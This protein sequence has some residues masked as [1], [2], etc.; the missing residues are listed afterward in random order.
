MSLLLLV[1]SLTVALAL[2][3]A[4]LGPDG[5]VHLGPLPPEEQDRRGAVVV[6]PTD[7]ALALALAG[8]AGTFGWEKGRWSLDGAPIDGADPLVQGERPGGVAGTG[9]GIPDTG[10]W[11]WSEGRLVSLIDPKGG[12]T[13]LDW[14]EEGRIRRIDWADGTYIDIRR[15]SFGRVARTAG[16]G[17][18]LQDWS[19]RDGRLVVT[20]ALGRPL[21]V[22]PGP[23]HNGEGRSVEV[24]D[25]LGRKARAWYAPDEGGAEHLVGWE[26]PRGL[27]TW[28]SRAGQGMSVVDG[29]GRSWRVDLD[30]AGQV[31]R[32]SDPGGQRWS[33]RRD[34][35]G[36]VV[37]I[38]EPAGR[39]H[40]WERDGEGRL[41]AVGRG[42]M[43]TCLR[44]DPEGRLIE[45]Q[46]PTGGLTRLDR[47]GAGH[48]LRI[49]D[50]LGNTVSFQRGM[51]G[52]PEVID[53]RVPGER[54]RIERDLLGRPTRVQGPDGRRLELVRSG[55]GRLIS[56][57][58]PDRG[59]FSLD[60]SAAGDL[61]RLRGPGGQALGLVYDALGRLSALRLPEGEAWT[62]RRDAAGEV[63]E[64]R[65][66]EE[67]V[68]VKRDA[69]GA[70]LELAASPGA[71]PGLTVRWTR[72]MAGR[73]SS[74]DAAGRSLR[75]LRDASGRLRGAEAGSWWL[76]LA[77]DAA[78]RVLTWRGSD[79]TV[80]VR[81]GLAGRIEQEQTRLSPVPMEGQASDMTAPRPAG[82]VDPAGPSDSE[83][84][85]RWGAP[86]T[87]S[88]V[89]VQPSPVAATGPAGTA[90]SAAAAAAASTPDLPLPAL[91]LLYDARGRLQRATLGELAWR[92]LRDGAGRLLRLTGPQE[93]AVGVARASGGAIT[94]VRHPGGSLER[95]E[96][97]TA[98]L[99]ATVEDPAGRR[100]AAR[101]VQLDAQ[102]RV[103][104]DEDPVWGPRTWSWDG[105]GHLASVQSAAG[106]SWTRSAAGGGT[107]PAG[108]DFTVDAQGRVATGHPP[109]GGAPAW[110]VGSV[111][112]SYAWG[113]EGALQ[114]VAGE[115]GAV[116]LV[117]DALGRLQG[118]NPERGE[119]WSLRYDA[120]GRLVGIRRGG[121]SLH[122]LVWGS[123]LDDGPATLLVSG[124]AGDHPWLS[125]ALG[126]AG[127]VGAAG[128]VETILD[129]GGD[130]RFLVPAGQRA[131]SLGA[132]PDGY[133]AV[134]LDEGEDALLPG[135]GGSLQPFPG[136]PVLGRAPAE[137]GAVPAGVALD[138]VSGQRTD[139]LSA[140]PWQADWPR[141]DAG[142]GALD[143]A[144]WAAT[145]PWSTPLRLLVAMGELP[146]PV[147]GT[148]TALP[149]EASALPWLP[150]S[151]DGAEPPLGPPLEALPLDE[152][153]LT[154][155]WIL[156]CLAGSP[157]PDAD[158]AA[159]TLAARELALPWLPPGLRLPL[160][161]QGIANSDR[162]LPPGGN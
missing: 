38:E 141:Q 72:D 94:L 150:A 92:S 11:R 108:E 90:P 151:L 102:G 40:A 144:P 20:D 53:G 22:R 89:Q 47:D 77:R 142:P 26:D 157:P 4:L 113:P 5:P 106:A 101:Q 95:I 82:P 51:D 84:L 15:D 76:V 114:W 64:L 48:V 65:H 80:E 139:G 110:G 39:I 44:W 12:L 133:P 125:G 57:R 116:E 161:W 87:P 62:L 66:G 147:P 99:L 140:L 8:S 19:W 148:W 120:R 56:L 59:A 7:G 156:A 112:L 88:A 54:W 71:N 137:G 29:A 42:P 13:R 45:I 36:R 124:P 123:A 103:A 52:M 78:G 115:R 109:A 18:R 158:L 33:W 43:P 104:S 58:D 63:V 130:P 2:P 149:P 122:R 68:G 81:R 131:L 117:H 138:P 55:A 155:A 111:A 93:L 159:R 21:E 32:V 23:G 154:T 119:P 134:S 16:P 35:Q 105:W 146:S 60:R 97:E 61:T 118:L 17:D 143:P 9:P 75:L 14:D 135:P 152:D 50:P 31:Q 91:V 49:I 69:S 127:V 73:V 37:G 136:G 79:G 1:L 10:R 28:V 34:A 85:S 98:A 96:W 74:V 25:A 67:V 3:P 145:G 132:S 153:P 162:P 128:L 126:P 107:G 27:Q 46:D 86:P 30:E 121:R 160:P 100:L 70:P 6:D 129:L 24:Q 41:A 83:L